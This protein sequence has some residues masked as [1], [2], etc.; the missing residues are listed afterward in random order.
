VGWLSGA[1]PVVGPA[2]GPAGGGCYGFSIGG[3]IY[4]LVDP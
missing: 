4:V 3:V 2:A 1:R